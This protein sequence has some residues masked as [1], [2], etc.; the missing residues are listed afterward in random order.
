MKLNNRELIPAVTP[1]IVIVRSRQLTK[2]P[3]CPQAPR[4]MCTLLETDTPE[5]TEDPAINV[6]ECNQLSSMTTDSGA[7]HVLSNHLINLML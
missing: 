2:L 4:T 7:D 5:S 1:G 6:E 3:Q